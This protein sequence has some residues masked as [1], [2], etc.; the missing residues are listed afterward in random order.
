M[1]FSIDITF[2]K[3]K[4]N[5]DEQYDEITINKNKNSQVLM[6]IYNY[7]TRLNSKIQSLL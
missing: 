4:F 7:T 5:L 1:N 6:K 3:I 2:L